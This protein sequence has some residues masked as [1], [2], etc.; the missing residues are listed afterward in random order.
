MAW[1]RTGGTVRTMDGLPPSRGT[2]ARSVDVDDPRSA[3]ALHA[4]GHALYCRAPPAIEE[5]LVNALLKETSVGLTPLRDAGP[6]S[7]R[8]EVEMFCARKGHVTAWH[9][10]NQE[11]FTIHLR[12]RTRWRLAPRREAARLAEAERRAAAARARRRR[13]PPAPPGPPGGGR[14]GMRSPHT[15][16]LDANGLL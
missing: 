5:A 14:F 8:G 11:N 7:G 9:S 3:V 1:V 15:F 13:P 10:D 4:A 12:G 6:L 2:T 16:H